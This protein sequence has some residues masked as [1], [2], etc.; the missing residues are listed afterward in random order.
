MKKG[1]WSS[2]AAVA[3]IVGAFATYRWYGGM[4]EAVRRAL[5]H[6]GREMTQASVQVGAVQINPIDGRGEIRQLHIGNPP[7]FRTPYAARVEQ[8]ELQ[9]DVR[10]L[11][12]QVIVIRKLVVVAPDISYEKGEAQTNFEALQKNILAY[13]PPAQRDATARPRKFIVE[14]FALVGA[15]ANAVAPFIAGAPVRVVLPDIR[16]RNIGKA[17]G[18]VTAG[19]LGAVITGALRQRLVASVS[20]ESLR[21]S[22]GTA[23]DDAGNR[24]KGWF[25]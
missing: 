20:F 2:A 12:E 18:G 10:T 5:H 22:L 15:K 1:L 24:V 4:D 13:L 14:E 7:G 21:R 23:I 11:A 17:Q 25:K 16:M 6:Y 8:I 19:E 9:L 3:L